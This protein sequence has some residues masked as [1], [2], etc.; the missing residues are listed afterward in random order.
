MD[1]ERSETSA[2]KHYGR[3]G[4]SVERAEED[5][6]RHGNMH[7]LEDVEKEIVQDARKCSC[8]IGQE[9]GV[10]V[11]PLPEDAVLNRGSFKTPKFASIE[12]PLTQ[13][14]SAPRSS[15]LATSSS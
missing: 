11:L 8:E 9:E 14:C 2:V 5:Q 4:A 12:R 7:G 13:D 6:D 15:R 3:C 10:Q 1:R